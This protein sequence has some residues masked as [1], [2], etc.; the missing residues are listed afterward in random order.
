M[1]I[2]FT[3]YQGTGNDFVLIDQR[4][5]TYIAHTAVDSIVRIC[6]R[7]FGIGADGLI[8]LE[9]HPIHDYEMVYFNADGKTSSMC[10]N[11]GRCITAFAHQIG[12]AGIENTFLAIDGPHISKFNKD[13]TV[14]LK[15][16]NVD[17]VIEGEDYYIIDTGS[18]H[19]II[20]VEDI[21][22]IDVKSQGEAIRYS[23]EFKEQGINVNFVEIQNDQLHV[24][25]YE[26]GVE[27]ETLSCGTGVT[28]AAIAYYRYAKKEAGDILIK[29]KTKGGDLTVSFT[30]AKEGSYTNIWLNGK[31][32]KVFSGHYQED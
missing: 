14:S 19:Y 18:P 17:Q 28:A 24:A 20:F 8:L 6:D 31:A 23:E 9:N 1:N 13:N 10:G 11:G 22:D 15:M 2:P 32:T 27:D 16:G 4:E 5:K 3:K 21:D 26:R 25:T 12:A 30:V 29:I 7:K